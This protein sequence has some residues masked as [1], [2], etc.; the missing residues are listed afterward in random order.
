M[1]KR[2]AKQCPK[3]PQSDIRKICEEFLMDFLSKFHKIS[4]TRTCDFSGFLGFCE[5]FTTRT[6]RFFW[7]FCRFST[8]RKLGIIWIFKKSPELRWSLGI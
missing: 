2:P 4:T 1:S 8:S 3:D 7:S 5:I 6:C